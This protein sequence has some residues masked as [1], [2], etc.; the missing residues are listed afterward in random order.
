MKLGFD[1]DNLSDLTLDEI[2]EKEEILEDNKE[3]SWFFF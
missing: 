1:D 3:S 2:I